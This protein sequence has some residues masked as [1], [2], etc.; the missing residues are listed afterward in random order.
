M[1]LKCGN[2]PGPADR[3]SF[4]QA[5]RARRRAVASLTGSIPVDLNSRGEGGEP[6]ELL[7]QLETKGGGDRGQDDGNA[8]NDGDTAGLVRQSLAESNQSIKT[9]VYE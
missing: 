9:T 4:F 5:Y 7:C 8:N 1:P 6:A 3:G 2:R